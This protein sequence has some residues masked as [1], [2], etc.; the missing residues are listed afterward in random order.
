MEST[1]SCF[2]GSDTSLSDVSPKDKPWDTHKKNSR[3][4]AEIYKLGGFDSYVQRLDDCAG[5]LTFELKEDDEAKTH[6]KLSQ[7]RFCRVRWCPVC[8]WRRSLSWRA[9]LLTHIPRILED[10]PTSRFLFLTL[11]FRNCELEDLRT[12]L[13]S[14]NTAWKRLIKRKAFP[15]IGFLKS[16]E[17]TRGKDGTAHPHFHCLLMVKPSYFGHAYISQEKWTQMWKES[18]RIDYTPIVHVKAIKQPKETNGK[19]LTKDL[20]ASIFE[21]AK[22]SVKE[23]DLIFDVDWLIGLTHQMHK[24]RAISLGG[25]FKE[26]LSEDD[27]KDLIHVDEEAEEIELT[28]TDLQLVFDWKETI[29]K[30]MLRVNNKSITY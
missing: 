2:D 25:V 30:Y 18:M 13:Q 11:T 3:I 27:P 5:S 15:A 22:Y 21:V 26:Y 17:V 7:A 16:V 28:D 8:Q 9:R 23:S 29:T 20:I 19:N 12:T 1:S 24:M 10:F 14:K 6:F 4:V